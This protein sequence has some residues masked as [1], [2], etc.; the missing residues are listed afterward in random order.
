MIRSAHNKERTQAPER[1]ILHALIAIIC[2]APLPFGSDRPLPMA[3][4]T[5]VIGALS[6]YWGI[7]AAKEKIFVRI[8]LGRIKLVAIAI[9]IVLL[10]ALLQIIPFNITAISNEFWSAAQQFSPGQKIRSSISVNR[11]E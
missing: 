6:I 3:I 9:G 11:H 7:F 2:L 8:S 4:I 5:T 1:H 10:F